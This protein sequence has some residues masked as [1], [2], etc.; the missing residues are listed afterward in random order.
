[1]PTPVATAARQLKRRSGF[2]WK[3]I[4]T[5]SPGAITDFETAPETPPQA[6]LSM[7]LSLGAATSALAAWWPPPVRGAYWSP[8]SRARRRRTSALSASLITRARPTEMG[9][10]TQT[11]DAPL[12]RPPT[13]PSPPVMLRMAARMP[14]TCWNSL[15]STRPDLSASSCLQSLSMGWPSTRARG[16]TSARLR[17]PLRSRSRVRKSCCSGSSPASC[18]RLRTTCRG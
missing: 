11:N 14:R 10:L 18:M 4:F 8:S 12:K 2:V 16:S 9:P 3:M 1:M 6:R 7:A 13:T 5:R 17:S 15:K